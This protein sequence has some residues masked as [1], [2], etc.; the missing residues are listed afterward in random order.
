MKRA[1]PAGALIER[2]SYG[3]AP[4]PPFVPQGNTNQDV[5]LGQRSSDTSRK[6]M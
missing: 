2:R 1:T 3:L 5:F 6:Q 4:N